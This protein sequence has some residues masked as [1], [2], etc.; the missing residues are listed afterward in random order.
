[1]SGRVLA[2]YWQ[3]TSGTYSFPAVET[4]S[5]PDIAR[6]EDSVD[7][8]WGGGGPGGPVDSDFFASRFTFYLQL[9]ATQEYTFELDCDDRCAVFVNGILILGADYPNTKTVTSIFPEG[10][11]QFVV[12]H[13]EHAGAA[14]IQLRWAI[15]AS[16]IQDMP[17]HRV[18]PVRS[19]E[20]MAISVYVNGAEARQGC[21][22]LQ[23]VQ[24]KLPASPDNAWEAETVD[25]PGPTC[26]YIYSAYR[27][28]ELTVP[29]PDIISSASPFEVTGLFLAESM[30]AMDYEFRVDGVLGSIDS[31]VH[32]NSTYPT[33]MLTPPPLPAGKWPVTISVAGFGYAAPVQQDTQSRLDVRY[34]LTVGSPVKPAGSYWGGFEAEVPGWGFVPS[35]SDEYEQIMSLEATTSN[36]G[37]EATVVSAS[38]SHLTVRFSRIVDHDTVIAQDSSSRTVGWRVKVDNTGS[39]DA[40][41]FQLEFDPTYTPFFTSSPSSLVSPDTS[42]T[43]IELSWNVKAR[44]EFEALPAGA[45][46]NASIELQSGPNLYPCTA[47]TVL[48]SAVEADQYTESTTCLLPDY[49]PASEYTVWLTATGTSYTLGSGFA[50]DK[51]DVPL[52]VNSISHTTSSAAGGLTITLEGLGF[53]TNA[54]DIVVTFSNGTLSYQG[55]VMSASA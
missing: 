39:W 54:S 28:P 48:S 7:I 36:P 6:L 55:F 44:T 51:M 46:S 22:S 38:T 5:S 13:V 41:Q 30:S 42:G 24:V 14:K 27:T 40:G 34:S 21:P 49:M 16:S 12:T 45:P 1:M 20:P 50:R 10:Q 11:H 15:G 8:N 26:S 43:S 25:L 23:S 9:P 33:L 52:S 35:D 17:W 32:G 29:L 3:L 18:T 53:S 19:G 31:T 47:A 4:F 37:F 2:E